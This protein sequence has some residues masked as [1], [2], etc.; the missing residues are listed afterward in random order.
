MK[1]LIYTLVLVLTV[2]FT[3]NIEY[4]AAQWVPCSSGLRITGGLNAMVMNNGILFAGTTGG[5]IYKSVDNGANWVYASSGLEVDNDLYNYNY[6][7]T[8]MTANGNF[9]FAATVNGIFRS[10]DNGNSWVK[11]MNGFY[12]SYES[13]SSF[14][15]SFLSIYATTSNGLYVTADL[16]ESW[17]NLCYLLP[18]NN[19]VYYSGLFFAGSSYSGIYRSSN[20]GVNWTSINNGLP[21][22]S[23]RR[24]RALTTFSG[25]LYLSID[26]GSAS[27][28]IYK[29]T[30]NG[31]SWA[32]ANNGITDKRVRSFAISG[33]KIFAGS[34]GKV[35]VSTDSGGV[36]SSVFDSAGSYVYSMLASGSN[37]YAGSAGMYFSSNGGGVWSE[38]INNLNSI[39]P[40]DFCVSGS[41]LFCSTDAVYRSTN[42][43][44]NWIPSG[45]GIST[46]T[47]CVYNMNGILFAGSN[48]YGGIFKSTNNGLN[49][50]NANTG[51]PDSM[52]AK[53]FYFYNGYLFASLDKF[54]SNDKRIYRSSNEGLNWEPASN[55]NYCFTF[56]LPV[57][58]R[59]FAGAPYEG[60]Y[61]TTN[62]GNNWISSYNG[63]V[64]GIAFINNKIFVSTTNAGIMWSPDSGYTWTPLMTSPPNVN[65]NTLFSY[66]NNLV[67]G[68]KGG[69]Y[70]SSNAGVNWTI[71]NTGLQ[72][73][74][75]TKL[76]VKDEY[77]YAATNGNG[78][79]RR[80][81]SE[82]ISVK[83]I[84]ETVPVD[85][86][87]YQNY[88]NPFNPRTVI[89]FQVAGNSD[90]S[91]IVYDLTGR[92]VK[93]MLNER[94]NP[95]VYETDFD[96]SA[97]SSGIYLCCLRT[98][99][100]SGTIK[101]SL[102]K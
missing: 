61:Y 84:S 27:C 43:G 45:N 8:A 62:N 14:Y 56:Y 101:M 12:W 47:S 52:G 89:R 76:L 5:G 1:K 66:A 102:I 87:L 85:F 50:F 100:F 3:L 64:S 71:M 33:S 32:A 68:T 60:L 15:T 24:V 13:V 90:V 96:G 54:F 97:L 30:D 2:H 91:L 58:T 77:I 34:Y 69:V 38:R 16:G 49:W 31:N 40:T 20:S 78:V 48:M 80:P 18:L 37:V 63:S 10:S 39:T 55:S 92:V 88:P 51:I 28:G 73:T 70:V 11:K 23:L 95:G 4:S 94:M 74:D 29:S 21:T 98:K 65:M 59:L 26:T 17:T 46:K 22:A 7:I 75:V 86:Q 79:Y 25:A 35:F 9:V 19:L 93:M 36:W 41:S 83:R 57:S 53:A 6:Y 81:K 42:N 44:N 82:V 67:A 72:L 99:D